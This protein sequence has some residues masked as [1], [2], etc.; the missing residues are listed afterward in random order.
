MTRALLCVGL[1]I[2]VTGYTTAAATYRLIRKT[3]R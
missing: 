1:L 3:M 2:A